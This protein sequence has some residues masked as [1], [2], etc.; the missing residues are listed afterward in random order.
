MTRVASCLLV[1]L[2]SG[3]VRYG[4][5]LQ[6]TQQG[7]RADDR[8]APASPYQATRWKAVLIAGDN[9]IAVFDN[10][11]NELARLLR[12]RGVDVVALFSA[13][14]SSRVAG[15]ALATTANLDRWSATFRVT[16]GEG[17]LVFATSHGSFHGLQ[18]T[19]DPHPFL[20][21]PSRLNR[22]VSTACGDAPTVIVI[23]ACH[24]GT[25]IRDSTI[26]PNRILLAAARE[27]R[28]SFGCRPEGRFTYYDGCLIQEFG[29]VTTWEDLHRAVERCVATKETTIREPASEPQ[30]FFGRNMKRLGLP[31]IQASP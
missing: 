25:F 14:G 18:L 10:A 29:T 24:S 8:S 15:A 28:R 22:I 19:R 30:A 6:D 7:Y 23:S 11:V 20:L 17:C 12:R 26:T 4:S 9:S 31:G 3:C 1:L 5:Q 13:A 27:I 2:L 16:E 21:A